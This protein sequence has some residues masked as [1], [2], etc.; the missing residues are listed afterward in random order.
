MKQ[1]MDIELQVYST[2]NYSECV[3]FL[4]S[5]FYSEPQNVAAYINMLRTSQ[6]KG[7]NINLL[8]AEDQIVGL[9]ATEEIDTVSH[10]LYAAVFS[11]ETTGLSEYLYM[12]L[13]QTLSD[14]GVEY[15][16]LGGSELETLYNF[17]LKIC[18]VIYR[19]MKMFVYMG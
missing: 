13:M 4:N 11:R 8:I 19:K 9:W 12:K 17:K 5:Y 16:N 3:N 14:D 18:P 6:L 7:I 15:L 1:D 10:G 2:T